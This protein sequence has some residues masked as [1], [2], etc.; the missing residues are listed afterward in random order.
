MLRRTG[1]VLLLSFALQLSSVAQSG[2]ARQPGETTLVVR[3]VYADERTVL[4]RQ[5]H[6]E[7]LNA[8]GV[9]V[10]E[11]FSMGD[12]NT[13][14][15]PVVAGNYM[16][17]VSG[18][19]IETT[20]TP[21][22]QIERS[23]FTH[24]EYVHVKATP[25]GK[26]QPPSQPA[27]N[28]STVSAADLNIPEKARKELQHAGEDFAKGD[29]KKALEETDKAIQIYPQFAAAYYGRGLI[30]M[31]E[32]D[33]AGAQQAFEKTIALDDH[34]ARAYTQLAR[35]KLMDQKYTESAGLA[36]KAL[37]LEPQNPQALA[38]LADAELMLGHYDAVL[39]AVQRIHAGPHSGLAIAHYLAGQAYEHQNQREKAIAEYQEFL[40]ESPTG[41]TASKV[42]EQVARL[43]AAGH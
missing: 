43:Q 32:K 6:V 40:N 27:P 31:Q 11:S 26:E 16:L 33:L 29:T 39:A 9:R 3:I 20:T 17:R 13:E 34:F 30:L 7:L 18:T 35:L 42:R 41:P 37:A 15:R 24:I 12:G 1:L 25:D 21:Q 38:L 36:T 28:S 5:L 4:D 23:E 8:S 22:F 19:G 2:R 14:I 10:L